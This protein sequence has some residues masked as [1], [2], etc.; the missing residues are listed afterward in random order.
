MFEKKCFIMSACP[1]AGKSTVAKILA[2]GLGNCVICSTDDLFMVDGEYRFDFRLAKENHNKNYQKFL[3]AMDEGKNVI[4]DNTNTN[5]KQYGRYE[6][7][8]LEHGYTVHHLYFKPDPEL[9]YERNVHEVPSETI[10]NMANLLIK[11]FS[12]HQ[13]MIKHGDN[14]FNEF[15]ETVSIEGKEA[16]PEE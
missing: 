16:I 13:P 6:E 11:D 7:A 8:A 10:D 5:R 2:A 15:G 1:G 9:S 4:V 12:E 14:R 3:K